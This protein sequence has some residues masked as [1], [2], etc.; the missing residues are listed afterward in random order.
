MFAA[1]RITLNTANSTLLQ[2][3]SRTTSVS[4]RMRGNEN[5]IRTILAPARMYGTTSSRSRSKR[6]NPVSR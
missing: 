2:V 5:R 1:R 4:E 3:N 6:R